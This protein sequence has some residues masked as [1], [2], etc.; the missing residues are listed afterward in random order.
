MLATASGCQTKFTRCK[1]HSLRGEKS[2]Q[3]LFKMADVDLK[4]VLLTWTDEICLIFELIRL[5]IWKRYILCVMYFHIFQHLS[6]FGICNVKRRNLLPVLENK[7]PSRICEN[8]KKKL[9][10]RNTYLEYTYCTCKKQSFEQTTEMLI[11]N[12]RKDK[13]IWHI[14]VCLYHI[15]IQVSWCSLRRKCMSE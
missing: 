10:K 4:C 5:Q 2:L 9:E 13:L 1:L 11:S 6:C 14:I 3:F 12:R 7:F 15:L 8:N